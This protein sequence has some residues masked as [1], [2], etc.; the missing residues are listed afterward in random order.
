MGRTGYLDMHSHILPGVDDG[1]KDWEMTSQMLNE[2]YSQGVRN[3]VA[4]PHN[5]PGEKKQDNE[6]IRDLVRQADELAKQIAPDFTVL[7]GNEVLYRRGIAQEIEDGHIL[8]MA[9]S[10]YLLVEFYP[11][12]RYS[13]IYQGLRELVEDGFCPIIAHMERV[14]EL[15]ESEEKIRDLRKLGVL[16]QVNSGSFMGGVFDRRPARLRKYVNS[17]F[18]HFLGSDCHNLT[19]RPPRMKDCV[20]KLSRKLPASCMDRLLYEN[21]EQFL[22]KKYI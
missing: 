18:V 22:Q 21:Q 3:I 16:F 14:Q 13:K 17:G 8:T 20:E 2:A 6:K 9:D 4:T 5:Y 7:C 11:K 1:S 19:T 10:R 15:F 12:E